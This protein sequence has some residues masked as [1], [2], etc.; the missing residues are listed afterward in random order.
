MRVWRCGVGPLN[1]PDVRLF[2]SPTVLDGSGT[3]RRLPHEITWTDAKKGDVI[4]A[5]LLDERGNGPATVKLLQFWHVI[6]VDDDT[7][8]V[9]FNNLVGAGADGEEIYDRFVGMLGLPPGTRGQRL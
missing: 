7:L 3:Y 6:E 2:R 1:A 9:E 5:L 8:D 4:L